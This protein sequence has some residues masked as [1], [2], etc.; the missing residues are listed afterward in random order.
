[1]NSDKSLIAF[2][3]KIPTYTLTIGASSNGSVSL[4]PAGGTYEKGTVV[5]IKATANEKY[6]FRAWSG[7]KSGS[8]NPETITMDGNRNVTPLFDLNTSVDLNTTPEQAMLVQNYPNPFS[9]ITTIPY[10][11]DKASNVKLS[12]FNLLGEKV[13]I[14]VNEQRT[15]GYHEVN[16]DGSNY[17]GK[18]M[19][20]GIY[21]FRLEIGN[22]PADTKKGI[23]IR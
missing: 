15:A 7:D 20:S 6:K 10:Q 9:S 16:W 19:S 4:D 11:L 23:L 17:N 14:L 18:P 13:S 2:F 3:E 21:F 1:M 5:T 22:N 8:V 12:V